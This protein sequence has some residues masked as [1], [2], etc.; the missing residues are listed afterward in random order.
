[1]AKPAW[2][3]VKAEKVYNPQMKL[4]KS[5]I[6]QTNNKKKIVFLAGSISLISFVSL[7]IQSSY[8]LAA[9]TFDSD[10]EILKQINHYN[11]NDFSSQNSQVTNVNHLR[12]VSP[13]DWAYEAMRSLT[14]RYGC[15]AGFPQNIYYGDRSITRYEFAAGLNSCL[16]QI[17]RLIATSETVVREDF[18]TLQRLIQE[19]E[20]ELATLGTRIDNLEQ[21]TAVLDKNQFSTTTKLTGQAIFAVSAGGVVDGDRIIDPT[22]ALITD[23]N[24]NATLL[25]RA[26]LDLDTSFYGTDNLKIRLDTGSNGSNDNAANFLEPNFS[27][28]LDYSN[29]PPRDGEIGIGRLYY[30]FQPYKNLRVNLGPVIIPTDYIDT[31]SYANLSFRDFSTEALVFNTI[32]FPIEGESSGAFAEWN[33]GGGAFRLRALYAAA[34][35]A[36]PDDEGIVRG[37][38]SFTMLLYPEN[39]EKDRGLF[40]D[41]YQG[42]VELEYAPSNTFVLR[43]QYTGGE[44]FD[45]HYDV[46][47]ANVEWEILPRLAVFGRYGYGSYNDTAF[48][49]I[50]PNYW[51]A[52]FASPDLFVPGAIAGVAAGQPFI[53][54]ELGDSTQTNFEVFYNYPVN[55]NIRI[56]P[57]VQVITNA[58]NQKNNNTII[59]GTLRAVFSF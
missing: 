53:A 7:I 22:G 18:E 52:G 16:N 23:D 26:N 32:L 6:H 39:E 49:D 19:F 50:N 17:E 44:V 57:L 5:K 36:N 42:M 29:S 38:S 33:P 37:L 43:L 14:E 34:D 20:V 51:M 15:I 47:G 45:S 10:E 58:G 3:E 28:I 41:F 56:T 31:N 59:T 4:E 46:F 25:Y 35:A 55:D 54:D 13:S 48:D 21:R 1:M 12:D 11:Y 8:A 2:L 40:G 27:S 30:D 9:P 24:P